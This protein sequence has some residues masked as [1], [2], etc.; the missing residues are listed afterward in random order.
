MNIIIK[1]VTGAPVNNGMISELSRAG[2][3]A[4][5][6][7]YNVAYVP[8]ENACYWTYKGNQCVAYLGETCEELTVTPK[9]T[10]IHLFSLTKGGYAIEAK[11]NGKKVG[12]KKLS[13]EDVNYLTDK[14]NRIELA[15]KYLV[16]E[17]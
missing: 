16:E 10:G 5:T 8:A 3:P 17:K 12:P 13:K 14:T 9:I 11:V 4:G 7:I 15:K 1:N 2:N 6:K